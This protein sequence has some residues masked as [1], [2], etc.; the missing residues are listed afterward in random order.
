LSLCTKANTPSTYHSPHFQEKLPSLQPVHRST[1][2]LLLDL[3]PELELF[4]FIHSLAILL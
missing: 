2:S 3:T 4:W 1:K